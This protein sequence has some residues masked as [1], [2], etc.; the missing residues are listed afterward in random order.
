MAEI[1]HYTQADILALTMDDFERAITYTEG[2]Q[3]NGG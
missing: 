1:L 2:R 3:G